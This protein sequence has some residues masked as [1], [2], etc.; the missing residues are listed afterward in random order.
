[1]LWSVLS[2][3][4]NNKRLFDRTATHIRKWLDAQHI[5]FTLLLLFEHRFT[6]FSAQ[7]LQIA[8]YAW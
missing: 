5:A 2:F 7:E 3:I 6:I 8:L 4:Y 1:V